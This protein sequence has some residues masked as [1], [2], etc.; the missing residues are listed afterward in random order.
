MPNTH[1][2]DS[3]YA[4]S[5]DSPETFWSH[6]AKQLSWAVPPKTIIER[7]TKT[8]QSG[9]KHQHWK[10]FPDGEISTSYN[11]VDRHVDAGNGQ[12]TAII[13]DSP[14]TGTQEKVSYA[15]LAE[16][17]ATLA[18][19]LREEGVKKGD[20]VLIYMPQIPAALIG[21]LA[22]ARLGAIHAV[23]FGGFSA[24]SLAQRIDASKP[25]VVLT[26]SCGI[27]GTKGPLP[28]QPLVRGA[29]EHS[30]H[31]PSKTIIWQREQ[32]RWDPVVREDGERNWQRLVKSA[33]NRGL[34]AENVPVKSNDGLYIIYTSGTTGAPKG[35]LREAGGHAVGLNCSMRYLFGIQAGDVMFCASDIGWVVGHSFICYAPLLAGATTVLFEGKPIGTPDA[36]TFWRVIEQHKVNAMFTAP[37]AL[38][39]IRREDGQHKFFIERGERNGL[40]S[41][42]ALFLAGE[43]SEPAVVNDYT[44][45]LQKY[46]APGAAVVD[47][48]WSSESGSPMT[49]LAQLPCSWHNGGRDK[50][51]KPLETRPGSAGKPMPGFDIR[52]VDDDG[53]EV[54]QGKTGNIVLGMP[55][56]PTGFT[57]LWEDEKRFYNGYMLRF[58]GKWLDTGDAGIID[59]DG[60]VHIHGR[61][62]DMINVAAH[63]LSTATLEQ[64]ISSHP[65]ITD[66]CVI[67]AP[68]PLK[69]HVPFAFVALSASAGSIPEGEL[70]SAIN[71]RVRAAVG[72]IATLG[73]V[74]VAQGV[75]PRTRSGKTL[76][77]VLKQMV[78]DAS[79][80]HFDKEVEVPATIEDAEVVE[81]AR[82][83]I[84]TYF[85][86]KSKL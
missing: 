58:E 85:T 31:K 30:K 26:A 73:G 22:T 79:E 68:D 78:E 41:L 57:T 64:A 38:R 86:R 59:K 35:V 75:I 39:A 82:K 23:V 6:E 5:L 15:Q 56:A 3:A 55:L 33:R 45:L 20:V 2:Q 27:E 72:P 11:C 16:E 69:G 52:V 17:V 29:Y 47:N 10:W 46:G 1:P 63:R 74:I 9:T 12:R 32:S 43:R 61:S 49:G 36:G 37:T 44:K 71:S 21:I 40:K 62:D 65:A 84:K 81:R 24:P 34:K 48:W 66:N 28:Y 42:R 54:P 77:R 19:V 76:R 51:I 67:P 14:V 8:L 50:Q 18:G 60:Y 25:R 83:A 80:G 4:A 13:W 7:T 53:N 70:L